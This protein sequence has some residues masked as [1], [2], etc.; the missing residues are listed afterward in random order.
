MTAPKAVT[1]LVAKWREYTPEF[2]CDER[3]ADMAYAREQQR[4]TCADELEAALAATPAVD[5]PVW[6]DAETLNE[7]D[8]AISSRQKLGVTTGGL[9]KLHARCRVAGEVQGYG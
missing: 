7:L 8:D 3:E 9:L 2:P 4:E 1:E 5:A 6:V